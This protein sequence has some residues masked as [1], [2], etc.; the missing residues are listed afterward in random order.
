[1]KNRHLTV[2]QFRNFSI[3]E[4]FARSPGDVDTTPPAGFLYQAGYLTLR[5]RIY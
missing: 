3:P 2:E 5:E 1:M 4:D